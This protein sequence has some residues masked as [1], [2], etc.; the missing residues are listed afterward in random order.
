MTSRRQ[1][2]VAACAPRL[3]YCASTRQSSPAPFSLAQR[4][5]QV[6]VLDAAPEPAAG[7]SALPA[8]VV[9]PH[10]SPDD[11]P[12]SQLT[13]AGVRATLTRAAG[14]LR[15]GRDYAASGVLERHESG[16]RR[17]PAAW[18]ADDLPLAAQAESLAGE[19][20]LTRAQAQ[21]A[22][23]PLNES[24]PAL[25]HLRAG[26]ARPAALVCA[27]LGAPGIAWRGNYAVARIDRADGSWRLRDARGDTLVE[28][29]LVVI[30]AGFD[31]LALLDD[32]L[33]LHALRGQ[34]AWGPMPGGAADAALPP[35]PVNGHGSLIAH[36]PGDGGPRWVTGSTFERA[37][38]TPELHAQD[39]AANGQ[40]LRELLPPAGAALAAQWADGRAQ[41]W[42]GVRATLPD[43]L[44]AVG[45]WR[46]RT[47]DVYESNMAVARV[48][49]AQAAIDSIPT[50]ALPIHLCTGLGARGLTLAVLAG[51][52]LA[53]T[54]HGE[55]LPLARS[56]AR[57]L[58]ARR[59]LSSA[60]PI[61][62]S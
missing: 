51:E 22:Q 37:Q 23:L 28:A 24:H 31:S 15:A 56:L 8:G 57:R 49:Q 5:W 29:E 6:S 48:H 11:R 26:W 45:A 10:V 50:D 13:R 35:F 39:H 62:A 36:L 44:P 14:L 9:A 18:L 33:P 12:L 32:S 4:G 60:A 25:W 61:K 1:Q 16:K 30:A 41:P 21:A 34:V 42:A 47:Y 54:L 52:L 46:W 40:R 3:P 43:R 59:F 17:R 7:A 27:M 55:P 20:P 2:T 58:R 38:A 53:A 19:H